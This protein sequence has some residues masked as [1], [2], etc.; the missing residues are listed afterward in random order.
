[1]EELQA[2]KSPLWW[3]A[4]TGLML[5]SI[6]LQLTPDTLPVLDRTFAGLALFA[7]GWCAKANWK[8]AQR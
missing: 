1:V 2:V 3:F 8:E 6:G 4:G 5:I 7:Y